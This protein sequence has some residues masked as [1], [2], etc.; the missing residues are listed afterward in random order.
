MGAAV[1]ADRPLGDR[2]R[3]LAGGGT[4]RCSW[5]AAAMT[6]AMCARTARP[7]LIARASAASPTCWTPSGSPARRSRI[8]CCPRRSSAPAQEQGPDEQHQ[9][10]ALW[11]NRRRSILTSRQHLVNEAE[12]LLCELPLELREQLPDTKAVRPTARGAGAPQPPPALRRADQAA[13][14]AARRLP[15]ADHK[16]W[17]ARRRRSSRTSARSCRPSGSTLGE[18]CG[19]TPG[20]SPSCWSRSA[21]PAG[22]PRAGS[23]A[24]TP[25]RRCPPRP[26]RGPASRSATATTPAATG[27]STRSF[28]GWR[29]PSCAAS[30]APRRIYANARA[31]GHTKK[32]ARRVLKRHLSD[33]IYRRMIRD[34]ARPAHPISPSS[35]HDRARSPRSQGWPDRAERS[36]PRSGIP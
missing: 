4:R 16:R 1:R 5:P 25:Q 31:S 27:A 22:S 13:P 3:R 26:P 9:L 30:R 15:R 11:H 36:E 7:G 8:R 12:Y 33:V 6:C 17:T 24:S 18:L 19:L 32:E 34:L 2:G 35:P 29:S 28:T 20:R 23:R 21:T 10:L 14:A